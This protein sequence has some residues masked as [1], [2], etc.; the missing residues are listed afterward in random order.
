METY[1]TPDEDLPNWAK[2]K[3]ADDDDDDNEERTTVEVCSSLVSV[4]VLG[5]VVELGCWPDGPGQVY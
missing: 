1:C 5:L 4:Q 3:V 2:E